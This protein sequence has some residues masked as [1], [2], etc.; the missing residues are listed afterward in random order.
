MW[1][2]MLFNNKNV[3]L[4][5]RIHEFNF[6]D[7]TKV[8]ENHARHFKKNHL[9]LNEIPLSLSGKAKMK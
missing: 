2:G 7:V 3:L 4:P 5:K 1:R 8:E 6:P 9:Q